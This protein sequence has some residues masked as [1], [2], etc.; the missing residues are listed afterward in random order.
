MRAARSEIK[1]IVVGLDGSQPAQAALEWTVGLA[2]QVGGDV[3]AVYAIVPPSTI[4]Y[5]FGA[6]FALPP[7]LD[8]KWRAETRREFEE[9]WCQPLDDSGLAYRTLFEEGRAADVIASTAARL[10]ADLV[11][12]GRRGRGNVADLVLGS[13]SHELTHRCRRPVVVISGPRPASS[14][15]PAVAATAEA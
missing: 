10:E 8:E 1:R 3:V 2:R 14:R 4:E 13:V 11:V 15:A 6:Q 7:Q 12:V 9:I 5:A